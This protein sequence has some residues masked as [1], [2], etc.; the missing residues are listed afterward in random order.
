MFFSATA[1]QNETKFFPI[2]ATTNVE[3]GHDSYDVIGH[4]VGQ[5]DWKNRNILDVHISETA[6]R[7][8]LKLGT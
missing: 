4:V 7:K 1:C 6:L 2:G 5:P 3:C 8:E